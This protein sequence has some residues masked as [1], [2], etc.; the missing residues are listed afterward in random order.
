MPGRLP[1]PAQ[2]SGPRLLTVC[3]HPLSECKF[4]LQLLLPVCRISPGPAHRDPR[5]SDNK[6][7]QTALSGRCTMPIPAWPSAVPEDLNVVFTTSGGLV[8]MTRTAPAG[9]PPHAPRPVRNGGTGTP[10]LGSPEAGRHNRSGVSAVHVHERRRRLRRLPRSSGLSG[11]RG[12]RSRGPPSPRPEPADGHQH[13]GG[14]LAVILPHTVSYQAK[15]L[16]P[17]CVR[18][19]ARPQVDRRQSGCPNFASRRFIR[20]PLVRQVLRRADPFEIC[21]CA[22]GRRPGRSADGSNGSAGPPRTAT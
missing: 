11:P 4:L 10:P 3:V 18:W 6:T 17:G 5:R 2:T 13:R 19:P 1:R 8:P 12:R 21:H 7:L 14:L 20:A 22:L 9:D 15:R 16:P